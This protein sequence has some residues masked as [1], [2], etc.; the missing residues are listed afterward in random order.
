MKPATGPV[1]DCWICSSGDSHER[2]P[3][4]DEVNT[5]SEKLRGTAANMIT[6]RMGK[7]LGDMAVFI[8][9]GVMFGPVVIVAVSFDVD[10]LADPPPLLRPLDPDHEIDRLADQ[11]ISL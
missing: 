10:H 3:P 5:G 1:I 7:C 6:A 11:T 9:L 8:D 4:P 2:P